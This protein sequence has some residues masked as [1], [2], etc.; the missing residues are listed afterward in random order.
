MMHLGG[1]YLMDVSRVVYLAVAFIK[2]HVSI[3]KD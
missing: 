3:S 1:S 2:M